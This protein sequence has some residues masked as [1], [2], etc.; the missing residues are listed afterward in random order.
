MSVEIEDRGAAGPAE[1]DHEAHQHAH[2]SDAT[3]IKV[4]IF[5]GVLTAIEVGTY[6]LQDPS[7]AVLVAVLFPLMIIKFAVV[8]GAFMHLRFDNPIFRRVFVFGLLL[9]VAVYLVALTTMEFWSD[10]YGAG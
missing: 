10:S 4:G 8:A 5:L 7:T 2:P 6:F 9:A 3:Y 1:H